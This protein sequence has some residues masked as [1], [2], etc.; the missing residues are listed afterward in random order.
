[1]RVK[2]YVIF[3]RCITCSIFTCVYSDK[4]WRCW[5]SNAGCYST[6]CHLRNFCI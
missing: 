3:Y 2:L 4:K 1:M 6:F 5:C